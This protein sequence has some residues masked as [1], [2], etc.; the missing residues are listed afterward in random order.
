MG[1]TCDYPG[2]SNK[3]VPG[4]C[5]GFHRFPV[6]DV[7]LR[8][9]WLVALG[10][11]LDTKLAKM[12]KLRVCSAHFSEEDYVSCPGHRKKRDLKRSAVPAPQVNTIQLYQRC[13]IPFLQAYC[14]KWQKT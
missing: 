13:S 10:F 6:T 2:C 11:K 1:R 12:K 14:L 9:L 3:D 8:E 5:H 4:S 7:A